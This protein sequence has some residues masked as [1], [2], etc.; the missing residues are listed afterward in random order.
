MTD[1][2]N[3]NL[4]EQLRACILL[5]EPQ[6]TKKD[7]EFSLEFDECMVDANEELLKQVWINLL[8]NAIKFSLEVGTILL[9]IEENEKSLTVIV[10][11]EGSQIPQEKIGKIFHKFYQADESHASKG[12][13]VGLA[14][15]RRIVELHR[16]TVSVKSQ[17]GITAFRV[18]LP[19]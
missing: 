4:S 5:L 9:K 17:Q 16:G 12:N 8:D 18:E 15:V 14:I 2:T 13:G 10:A 19:K 11:N 6:W 3:Y 1:V 7:I